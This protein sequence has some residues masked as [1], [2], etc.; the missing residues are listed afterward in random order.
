MLGMDMDIKKFEL[1]IC[2]SAQISILIS[3]IV[4][5]FN[6]DTK[7]VVSEFAFYYFSPSESRFVFEEKMEYLILLVYQGLLLLS[8]ETRRRAATGNTR[9]REAPG[10]AG[11]PRSLGQRPEIRHTSWLLDC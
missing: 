5:D 2:I 1:P 6:I 10:T 8:V 11:G 7:M 4:Y 9:S 3:L